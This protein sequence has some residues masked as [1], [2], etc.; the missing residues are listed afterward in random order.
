MPL[1]LNLIDQKKMQTTQADI[2]Y[3]NNQ[4]KFWKYL[5][6]ANNQRWLRISNALGIQLQHQ[7]QEE[8]ALIA[9]KIGDIKLDKDAIQKAIIEELNLGSLIKEN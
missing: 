8:M 5:S 2:T 1:D 7:L 6:Y 9:E 3:A 4:A